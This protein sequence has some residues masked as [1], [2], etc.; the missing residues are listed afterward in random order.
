GIINRIDDFLKYIE[1][2][3]I[4]SIKK[5]LT[6]QREEIIGFFEDLKEF[7]QTL[8]LINI[9]Y[10]E[11]E[12]LLFGKDTLF[13]RYQQYQN[14][15]ELINEQLDTKKENKE[16]LQ[17]F[18]DSINQT[19]QTILK[20]KIELQRKIS[21]LEEN[22]K[23]ARQNKK[24]YENEKVEV[25]FN[26]KQKE[27]EIKLNNSAMEKIKQDALSLM[28]KRD[29]LFK[30]KKE[31]AL[32]IN[33]IDEEIK[34]IY[35]KLD[36][37]ANQ[38]EMLI[39]KKYEVVKLK[40]NYSISRAK[41]ETELDTIRNLFFESYRI[42]L[43]E[44]MIEDRKYDGLK[45]SELRNNI[46][47][48]RKSIDEIGQTNFLAITEYEEAKKRLDFIN[49]QRE[50]ILNSKEKLN[51]LIE[52]LDK[53]LNSKF[54]EAFNTINENFSNIFKE[55]FRGGNAQMVLTKPDDFMNTGI[56]IV[57]QPPGKNITNISLLSGGETAL[58]ALALL[59]A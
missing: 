26:I 58:S 31:Q 29:S 2:Q 20:K 4:E 8:G 46:I 21:A 22:I 47:N 37:L 5:N 25:A 15:I 3:D 6:V 27:E 48:A 18:L 51:I 45:E 49:K 1:S 24:R 10:K 38:N 17:K 23:N 30:T 19:Q 34:S 36:D 56:E 35:I 32:E 9:K 43:N 16:D 59:F 50:D 52:T 41:I 55:V 12:D 13:S 44:Q 33:K 40:E 42:V 7:E 39:R 28:E 54:L 53:N 11:F 57:I 14:A